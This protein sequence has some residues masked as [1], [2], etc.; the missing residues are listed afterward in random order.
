MTC[1]ARSLRPHGSVLI[2]G[3]QFDTTI[4]RWHTA[5]ATGRINGSNPCSEYMHL[6]NSACNL[7]S[8]NLL[9]YLD[10]DDQFDI[11]GF[12]HTIETMFTAQEILVGR[13]DYPTEPDRRDEPS[14]P[15]ARARLRKPR[16]RC[17][18]P[19]A[20]RTTAKPVVRWLPR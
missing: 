19:S 17:S 14:V 2:P 13:A 5:H 15:S 4:N 6:D 12:K 8:I 10:D 3:L 7:A 16:V 20:C 9:K 11:D 1:G 18:W